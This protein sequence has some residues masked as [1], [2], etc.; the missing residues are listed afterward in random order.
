MLFYCKVGLILLFDLNN[1]FIVNK[2]YK[3]GKKLIGVR[4]VKRME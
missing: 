1:I 4:E 3:G 2:L